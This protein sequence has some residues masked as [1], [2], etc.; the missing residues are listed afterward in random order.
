MSPAAITVLDSEV[1]WQKMPDMKHGADVLCDEYVSWKLKMVWKASSPTVR[2]VLRTVLL[3]R[4]DNH[5]EPVWVCRCQRLCCS[6]SHSPG[7][8]HIYMRWRPEG[9][10]CFKA[11]L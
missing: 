8:S 7:R 2:W 11:E 10:L 3:N 9:M 4:P 6:L 1:F 5:I